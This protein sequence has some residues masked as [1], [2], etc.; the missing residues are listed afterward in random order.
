MV[1]E[2]IGGPDRGSRSFRADDPNV[3]QITSPDGA[4]TWEPTPVTPFEVPVV[5]SGGTL[6]AT[7]PRGEISGDGPVI[8]EV[9]PIAEES[10]T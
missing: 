4:F 3:T 10:V 2:S 5:S 7:R 8:I 9:V 6:H 1:L